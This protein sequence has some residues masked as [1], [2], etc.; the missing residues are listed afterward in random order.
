VNGF[1]YLVDT[2]AVVRLSR[3]PRL[4]ATW[5][6]QVD[7]G[8]L[9]VCPLTELEFLFGARSKAQRA[10]LKLALSHAYRVSSCDGLP[11]AALS[12][13]SHRGTPAT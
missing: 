1:G 7:A 8:A 6:T 3:D 4:H 12:T 5:R 13:S 11:I 9:A 2:S 10:E